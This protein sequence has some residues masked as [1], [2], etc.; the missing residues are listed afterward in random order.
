MNVLE[1]GGEFELAFLDA[2]AD[3]EEAVL[4]EGELVWGQ[5][6]GGDLGT[7]VR[8]GA[9]NVLFVESPVEGDGFSKLLDE[10]S[11]LLSEAAFPHKGGMLS[12][13]RGEG[14]CESLT[15]AHLKVQLSEHAGVL[16][17]TLD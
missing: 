15:L 4:D 8:D 11:G 1:L 10:I 2:L 13:K 7:S 14:K 16:R 12:P 3:G 5:D 17:A 6:S 9:L